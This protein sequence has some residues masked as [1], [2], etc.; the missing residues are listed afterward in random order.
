[1]TCK[2]QNDGPKSENSSEISQSEYLPEK[3]HKKKTQP[4]KLQ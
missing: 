4:I 3:I 1:M 2:T